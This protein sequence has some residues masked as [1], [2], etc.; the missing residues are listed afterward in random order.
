MDQQIDIF[1]D[2]LHPFGIGNEVGREI[3]TVKLHAFNKIKGG[4]QTFGFFHSDHAF[5]A[6]FIHGFGHNLA[7]GFV[8]V[9]RDGSDLR[10]FFSV[11]GRLG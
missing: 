3:A 2:A 8:V 7:D 10:D 4:F 1:V 9:G 5:F 11:A 6:D